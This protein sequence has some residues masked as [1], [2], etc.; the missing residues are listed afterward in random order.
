MQPITQEHPMGCAIACVAYVLQCSYK[1]AH[2]LFDNQK[3]A[4][5]SGYYMNEIVDAL[6]KADHHYAYKEVSHQND[7]AIF[8]NKSIVFCEKCA[9]YLE[10]HFLCYDQELNQWMNPW[11]NCPMITPAKSSFVKNLPSKI[12]WV[13]YATKNSA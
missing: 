9:D 7:E 11:S 13:C 3:G 10:G 6:T 5:T 12:S 4:W 8:Q 2:D 1:E